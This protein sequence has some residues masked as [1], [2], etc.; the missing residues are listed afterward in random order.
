MEE[1]YYLNVLTLFETFKKEYTENNFTRRQSLKE[2]ASENLK[3]IKYK[4]LPLT[5]III[6]V[7]FILFIVLL[8][9]NICLLYTSDAADEL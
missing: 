8:P 2:Y 1:K 5:P 4:R 6:S 7:I 9:S 3:K